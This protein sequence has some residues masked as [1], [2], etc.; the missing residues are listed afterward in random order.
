M[1]GATEETNRPTYEET[2]ERKEIMDTLARARGLLHVR[3]EA[4]RAVRSEQRTNRALNRATLV[5]CLIDALALDW[6][7]DDV[8]GQE[9]RRASA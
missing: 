7:E 1:N 8:A 6:H 9:P 3:A 5:Q 4:H 2:P